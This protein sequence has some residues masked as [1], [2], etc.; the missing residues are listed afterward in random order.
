MFY[1]FIEGFFRENGF[2]FSFMINKV[3]HCERH[4]EILVKTRGT[5]E[6]GTG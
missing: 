1:K 5:E 6:G 3:P 4:M 2:F